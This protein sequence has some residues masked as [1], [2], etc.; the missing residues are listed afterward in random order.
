MP[1]P[2]E[3][4]RPDDA[5][6]FEQELAETE[7]S[8]HALK[9][10]YVQVQQDQQ[11][12]RELEQQRQHIQQ[13]LQQS[14]RSYLKAELAQIQHQLEILETRLESQLFDWRSLREP[15]WQIVRFGGLGVVFGWM[16]A[17]ATLNL[18]KPTPRP[19][20]F[21]STAIAINHHSFP[22]RN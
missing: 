21:I 7:R 2:Q 5:L 22:N 20:S 13:E 19:T 3:S 17:F 12:Q 10:R 15:F 6:N 1:L 9:S 16:L 11:Q 8:L 4:D 14:E 18:P